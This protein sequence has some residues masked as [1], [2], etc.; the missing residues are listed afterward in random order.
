M[1]K[2]KNW[3]IV[4]KQ[5][6]SE[7]L[8][9]RNVYEDQQLERSSI[10]PKQTMLSRNILNGIVSGMAFLLIWVIV[11]AVQMVQYKPHLEMSEDPCGIWIHCC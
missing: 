3:N 11:S 9:Y 1:P 5:K 6:M 10:A 4:K 8:R 7:T 2:K